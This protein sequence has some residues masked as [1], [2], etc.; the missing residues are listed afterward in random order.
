MPSPSE[1]LGKSPSEPGEHG[2]LVGEDVAEHVL[3]HDDVERARRRDEAHRA[4]IDELVL[5]A[6]ARLL[7]RHLDGDLAPQARRLEHVRLVDRRQQLASAQRETE[8]EAH[9][10]A[11]LLVGVL[12]RVDRARAIAHLLSQARLAEVEAARELAHEE[13]VDAFEA[14]RP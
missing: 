10:A 3:G 9:D 13:D 2:R 6:H 8:R 1:A 14:V 11:H 5:E 12:E 4:R 7:R